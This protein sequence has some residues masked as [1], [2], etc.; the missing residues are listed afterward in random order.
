MSPSNTCVQQVFSSHWPGLGAP[1]WLP[2]ARAQGTDMA[3]RRLFYLSP[4]RQTDT[5]WRKNITCSSQVRWVATELLLP[6]ES[7][8]A[9]Q[10]DLGR[11]HSRIPLQTPSLIRSKPLPRAWQPQA[12]TT[13][14][15]DPALTFFSFRQRCYLT[16][17]QLTS[18]SAMK[19][20]RQRQGMEILA[21]FQLDFLLPCSGRDLE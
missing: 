17:S 19:S 15:P 7:S 4:G 1:D 3:L 11:V 9:A 20:L 10:R 18:H 2:G 21:E 6:P 13:S 12:G 8:W 5:S 14:H 16:Y